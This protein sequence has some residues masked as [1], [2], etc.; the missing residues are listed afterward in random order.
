MVDRIGGRSAP[1]AREAILAAMK[2]QARAAEDVHRSGAETSVRSLALGNT[3]AG[4]TAAAGETKAGGFVAALEKGLAEIDSEVRTAES[5]PNDLVNG[6][7]K[8]LS[9]VAA[10]LKTAELTLR[11]SMEIRNKLLDAYREVMRMQV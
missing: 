4:E 1:L 3:P 7:V 2:A 5:L 10:R 11:F 6:E 8:D 9:E